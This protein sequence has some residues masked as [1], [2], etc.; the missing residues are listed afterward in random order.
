MLQLFFFI[1][2]SVVSSKIIILRNKSKIVFLYAILKNK[3]RWSDDIKVLMKNL[4][5][6]F[7]RAY[8]FNHQL[9]MLVIILKFFSFVQYL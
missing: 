9:K 3:S 1:S 7:K 4:L 8:Y 5:S 6:F 2:S